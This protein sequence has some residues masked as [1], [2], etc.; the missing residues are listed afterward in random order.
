MTQT[1]AL[2]PVSQGDLHPI[3]QSYPGLTLTLD[4]PEEALEAALMV[5]TAYTGAS[6]VNS[7]EY[8]TRRHPQTKE[9]IPVVIQVWGVMLQ[10][11]TVEKMDSPG[12]KEDSIRSVFRIIDPFSGAEEYL[13][14]VSTAATNFVMNTLLKVRAL[15][16][17]GRPL[18]MLIREKKLDKGRTYNF[19]I[20]P[21][22]EGSH[23]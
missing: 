21:R 9:D 8:L 22:P 20:V 5:A 3:C 19:Q 11:I 10:A 17:W 18:Y 12:E 2:V 7:D 1:T 13:S 15:G 4:T 6:T 16:D 14:F 23:E